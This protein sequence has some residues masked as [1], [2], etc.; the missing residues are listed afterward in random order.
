MTLSHNLRIEAVLKISEREKKALSAL[1]ETY[2]SSE[3]G[4]CV[5]S[6]T[7]AE[8]SGME[9][10]QSRNALRSLV[11]KGLAEYHRG[12]FDDDGFVAGSGFCVSPAGAK[13]AETLEII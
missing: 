5:Y 2:F 7:V 1:Y 12:L 11:R 9:V 8:R 3:E 4:S 10:N 6:R 13:L